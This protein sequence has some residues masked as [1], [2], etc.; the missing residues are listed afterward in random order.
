MR[1][2]HSMLEF[3]FSLSGRLHL[4]AS[5]SLLDRCCQ[6]LLSKQSAF[7]DS[8]VALLDGEW[9]AR[10][11]APIAVPQEGALSTPAVSYRPFHA[12]DEHWADCGSADS[13]ALGCASVCCV[14]YGRWKLVRRSGR[15]RAGKMLLSE[16]GATAVSLPSASR[17]P[18]AGQARDKHRQQLAEEGQAPVDCPESDEED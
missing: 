12:E 11:Q 18:R 16:L 5:C 13:A 8:Q 14:V 7:P 6:K 4:G 10:R 9:R 3:C 1:Q 15:H 2:H 17:W